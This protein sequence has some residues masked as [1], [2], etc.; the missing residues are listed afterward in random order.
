MVV[1]HS[2]FGVYSF[3][4]SSNT[5]VVALG[6][7]PRDQLQEAQQ[8]CLCMSAGAAAGVSPL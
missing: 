2:K 4:L 1:L 8:L 5:N 7:C 6:R 3:K